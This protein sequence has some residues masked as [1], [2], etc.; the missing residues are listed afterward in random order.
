MCPF[1][2][3]KIFV[4]TDIHFKNI[5]VTEKNGQCITMVKYYDFNNPPPPPPKKKKKK[6]INSSVCK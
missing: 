2:I 5:D 3:T 6:N 1:Y 4:G